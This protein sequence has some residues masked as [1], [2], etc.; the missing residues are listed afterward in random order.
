M[1]DY[2]NLPFRDVNA[3]LNLRD[4]PDRVQ[5]GRWVRLINVE[6][7]Q[8][9]L[10][11][12]RKGRTLLFDTT[13]GVPVHTIR[14]I[15]DDKHL[16]GVGDRIY[17]NNDIYPSTGWSGNPLNIALFQ[18]GTSSSV[19]GYLGDDN[20]LRKINADGSDYKW[21]ITA[22]LNAAA[23]AVS[24]A[25]NLNSAAPSA[26]TYDWRYTYGNSITQAESNP[27]PEMVVAVAA[28]N[29]QVN[30]SVTASADGQ[31]DEIRLY[32]R[33]GVNDQGDSIWRYVTK[34]ANISGIITD[35]SEDS[36]I[37]LNV[38]MKDDNYVPFTSVDA[39]GSTLYEV[40]L[41]YIFGPFLGKY[42]LAA[43][44]PNRPGHL[45][46]T[47]AERPDGADIANNVRVSS[48]SE[49]LIGGLIY[50]GT[51]FAVTR[52]NFYLIDFGGAN[53]LPTFV[54]RKTPVG[55]GAVSPWAFCT[56]PALY[57]VS[58]D[59]IFETDGQTPASPITEESLRPL[60][61][62]QTVGT[63]APVD[64]AYPEEIHL[65]YGEHKLH[66]YYRGTDGVK[67]HF[68]LELL[69][70][71]WARHTSSFGDNVSYLDENQTNP[72]FLIGGADGKI[73]SVSG[74]TD[75]GTT[76]TCNARTGSLDFG[77]PQT[78]KEFGN[79]IVDADP[80]GN[81]I[82]LTPFLN[83]EA[84]S[85]P[86]Q[87]MSGSGRQKFPL[88]LL[89]TYAYSIALDYSWS[90]VATIF[91]KDFLWRFDEEEL[92]H[93]EF[94]DTT[95]GLSGW[96]HIRDAYICWRSST[97][98]TLTISVDGVTR[99]YVVPH[100]SGAKKKVHIHLDPRKGKV[101]RYQ[102]DGSTAFRLYG[103]EC[104][105]RNKLWNTALGYQLLTP[106]GGADGS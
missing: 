12:T 80:N 5:E 63:T 19:W 77:R 18:P 93:W 60:F 90:G 88:S 8:E 79:V 36:A 40:I 20:Q 35:N 56:G 29:Q 39:S 66:F 17:R 38:E 53:A 101:F 14:R 22:P 62:G 95:H 74:T 30:V 99:T 6:S 70:A 91:Q 54:G 49:P 45:Y 76:I 72:L 83:A 68:V 42:I 67:Y 84:T 34:T 81:I 11:T 97:D 57:F 33:G 44:D 89:D 51:P 32:R 86:T 64:F 1:S 13:A 26:V 65:S 43:G 87:T 61:R 102:L 82:T 94:P 31:V 55:R 78:L 75:D 100:T 47:N 92:T 7:P 37:A 85:L 27:S 106:F 58:A 105:I 16:I 25:G 103:D 23:A 98:G 10:L 48:P 96:Q 21:G 73:Y 2:Q 4:A 69:Y 59:G 104:E 71:R 28:V 24:G 46:W 9:A 52:D 15:S 50:N 41:P 3:G